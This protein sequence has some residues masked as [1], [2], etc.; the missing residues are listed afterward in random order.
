MKKDDRLYTFIVTHTSRSRSR[1]RRI[2]IHKRW[3]KVA[4]VMAALILCAAAYGLIGMYRE[5]AH[6][7]VERENARLRGENERQRQK[8]EQLKDRVDAIEDASRRL[9]EM[10]GVTEENAQGERGAGGPSVVMDAAS[11]AAVEAHAAQLEAQLKTYESALREKSRIPSIWPVEGEMTDGFGGRRNPFGGSATE[12]HP[13]QDIRAE[14]GTPVV[15]AANGTVVFAGTQSGY[16]QMV[17][18]SHGDGLTTRYAHLSK[19]EVTVGQEIARGTL[20]GL[21]GSTGRSTGPHLHYEV[22]I[23][24]ESVNPRAYLPGLAEEATEDASKPQN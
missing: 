14:R 11:I 24:G 3:L 1:I 19:L 23:N 10:S 18:V 16:G 4:P 5:A 2:C 15:A 13:G 6:L 8:L 7:R 22:R 12:F 21:V 9:A 17:E 20:V